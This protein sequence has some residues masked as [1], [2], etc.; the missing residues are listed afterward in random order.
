MKDIIFKVKDNKL[1][2]IF[3]A[4]LVL[5]EFVFF[6]TNDIVG[7]PVYEQGN[8]GFF[9]ILVVGSQ[10]FSIGVSVYTL[11]SIVLGFFHK[12][13]I[14]LVDDLKG[15]EEHLEIEEPVVEKEEKKEEDIRRLTQNNVR[16][17][18]PFMEEEI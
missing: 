5:F 11:V 2:V 9:G 12:D 3:L 4:A 17:E 16:K 6:V 10:L 18:A 14:E 15:V 13:S 7:Y 8:L 1:N